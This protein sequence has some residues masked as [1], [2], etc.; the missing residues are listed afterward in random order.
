MRVNIYYSKKPIKV[1]SLKGLTEFLCV[2]RFTEGKDFTRFGIEN[3]GRGGVTVRLLPFDGE[4]IEEAY[5]MGKKTGTSS[6]HVFR[7]DNEIQKSP[8]ELV[9][10]A[11]DMVTQ[12]KAKRIV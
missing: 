7:A 10:T 6:V 8:K 2:V 11:L 3:K 5:R 12:E 9:Q 1:Q 4:S